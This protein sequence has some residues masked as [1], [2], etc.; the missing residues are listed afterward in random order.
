MKNAAVTATDSI[1]EITD[2]FN[3]GGLDKAIE[4]AGDEFA[5]LATKAAEHAPDMVDTAV[6][7]IQSFAQGVIDNREEILNAAEE[8]VRAFVVGI[9]KILPASEGIEEAGETVIDTM[10]NVIDIT[11]KVLSSIRAENTSVSGLR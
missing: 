9:A 3:N 11:G 10:D 4:T 7:F 8:T 6:S 5:G 1:N 2:A